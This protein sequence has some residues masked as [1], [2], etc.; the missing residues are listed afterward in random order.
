MQDQSPDGVDH[1]P[2]LP[3]PGKAQAQKIRT[4][5]K[6]KVPLKIRQEAKNRKDVLAAPAISR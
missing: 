3:T 6:K 2:V 1:G 5:M 4:T